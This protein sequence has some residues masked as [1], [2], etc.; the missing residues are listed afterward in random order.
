MPIRVARRRRPILVVA[1]AALLATGCQADP[2]SVSQQAPLDLATNAAG[3][4]YGSAMGASGR[5]EEP[6][7]IRVEATNGEEGYVLKEDLYGGDAEP[8]TPEEAVAYQVAR[9][10]A[11]VTAAYAVLDERLGTSTD[12]SVLDTASVD[13]L[14]MDVRTA[15]AGGTLATAGAD[16]LDSLLTAGNGGE[17]SRPTGL[18]VPPLL[19]EVVTAADRA[20]VRVVPV[21]ESDGVTLVGEF[22][23]G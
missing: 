1:V 18:D 19:T 12:V 20:T 4:T 10:T 8:T 23:I 22:E 14:L 6:D 21:Y 16:L 5:D 2:S 3:L 11:A 15:L 7:L 9:E 13:A 17:V